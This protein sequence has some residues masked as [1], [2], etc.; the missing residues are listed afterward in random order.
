L[1]Q[2]LQVDPDTGE[3]VTRTT[4]DGK[5]LW[6][7]SAAGGSVWVLADTSVIQLAARSGHVIRTIPLRNGKHTTTCGI[8]AAN[9]AVWV[10]MGDGM[11]S[12]GSA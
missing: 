12:T 6:A 5:D 9:D 11:C 3:V 8:A 10:S 7:L 4:F 2:V 1:Q